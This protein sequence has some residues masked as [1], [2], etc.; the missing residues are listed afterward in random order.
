VVL[1]YYVHGTTQSTCGRIF[2]STWGGSIIVLLN[3]ELKTQSQMIQI[4]QQIGRLNI[5][6]SVNFNYTIQH[7]YQ[8]VAWSRHEHALQK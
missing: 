5:L 1:Y 3:D 6:K 4:K 8:F 2:Y 7:L